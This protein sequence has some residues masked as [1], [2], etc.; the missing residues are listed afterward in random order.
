MNNDKLTP[1]KRLSNQMKD[2]RANM[3]PMFRE[4]I[5][6][7]VESKFNKYDF[8]NPLYTKGVKNDFVIFFKS[9]TSDISL[10]FTFN[11]IDLPIEKQTVYATFNT[12]SDNKTMLTSSIF[13]INDFKIKLNQFNQLT[14]NNDRLFFEDIIEYFSQVFLQSKINIKKELKERQEYLNA[15]SITKYEE[16]KLKQLSDELNDISKKYDKQYEQSIIEVAKLPETLEIKQLK[17]KMENLMLTVQRKKE[18]IETKLEL[19]YL[20]EKKQNAIKEYN[21]AKKIYEQEMDKHIKNEPGYIKYNLN[22]KAKKL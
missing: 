15:L 16:L 7:K 22:Y 11:Y 6:N 20:L 10:G 8:Y 2:F 12:T 1:M 3:L 5:L 19:P 18:N 14:K 21:F 9:K 17:L 13:S 4:V